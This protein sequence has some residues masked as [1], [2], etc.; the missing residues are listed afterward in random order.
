MIMNLKYDFWRFETEY[1]NI[2]FETSSFDQ[3][4][5]HMFVETK[6]L[7]LKKHMSHAA[8]NEHH[9]KTWFSIEFDRNI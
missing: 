4:E 8:H 7:G 3:N 5:H 2:L 1:L 6:G 9:P